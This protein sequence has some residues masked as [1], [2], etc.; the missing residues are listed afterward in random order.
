MSRTDVVVS[1]EGTVFLFYLLSPA[2]EQWVEYNVSVELLCLSSQDIRLTT[3]AAGSLYHAVQQVCLGVRWRLEHVAS[4]DVVDDL[5][6]PKMK[7]EL[8]SRG[9]SLLFPFAVEWRSSNDRGELTHDLLQPAAG[10]SGY[11]IIS[12]LLLHALETACNSVEKISQ[13]SQLGSAFILFSKVGC[14][15]RT[16]Q[17]SQQPD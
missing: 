17:G 8:V 5:A 1:P 12:Q 6:A 14:H 11:D 2:A 7:L 10:S 4:N 16:Y 13:R 9:F 15:P 3:K